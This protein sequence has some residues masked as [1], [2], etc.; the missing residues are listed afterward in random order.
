VCDYGNA[1]TEDCVIWNFAGNRNVLRDNKVI[2]V[3][4]AEGGPACYFCLVYNTLSLK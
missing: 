1:A 2:S 3:Y 4:K